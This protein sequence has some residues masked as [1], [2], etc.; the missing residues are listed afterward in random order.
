MREAMAPS[1]APSASVRVSKA[2][3]LSTRPAMAES[4]TVL[5]LLRAGG[6]LDRDLDARIEPLHDLHLLDA[7]EAGLHL[8]DLEL[9]LPL[10][11]VADLGS[12]GGGPLPPPPKPRP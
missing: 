8:A 10:V 7:G 3:R 4:V 6:V 2:P 11:L 5:L 1:L 12:G 9:I